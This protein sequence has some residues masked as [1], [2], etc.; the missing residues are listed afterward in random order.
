MARK[1]KKDYLIQSVSLACSLLEQ[2]R[3][4]VSELKISELSRLL[5]VSKNSVFRLLATL[6]NR[7]YVEKN[8]TTGAYHLG[9][10]SL[11]LGETCLKSRHLL[12]E[13]RSLLEAVSRESGETAFMA[14]LSSESLV[15][16]DAVEAAYPVK[17]VA[18]I[19]SCLP[20]YS[21]AAGKAVLA[22]C[23]EE[24]KELYESEEY[25]QHREQKILSTVG[26]LKEQEKIRENGYA[27]SIGE[28]ETGANAVAAVIRN[29]ASQVIG[30]LCVAGPDFR[31]SIVR[32]NDVVAPLVVKAAM[33]ASLRMGYKEPEPISQKLVSI[34]KQEFF[35]IPPSRNIN[36]FDPFLYS[37]CP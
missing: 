28:F 27:I 2:F 36:K 22:C 11:K 32:I 7:N 25:K 31:L 12:S 29:H 16:G 17:V 20:L 8:S 24:L 19:G 1:E 26:W 35:D 3:G 9:V 13:G 30:V 21:T 10:T 33:E 23:G 4:S 34:E 5:C 6:E 37:L 14:V 18:Q 15:C